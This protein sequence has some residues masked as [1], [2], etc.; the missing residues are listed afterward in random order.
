MQNRENLKTLNMNARKFIAILFWISLLQIPFAL[1]AQVTRQPFLQKLAPTSITIS[2]I[3]GTGVQG[4]VIYGTNISKLEFKKTESEEEEIYHEVD[5]KDL[6]PDTKYYYTV[7]GSTEGSEDTYFVTSPMPGTR[8]HVRVWVISDF[9]QTNS[10]QNNNREETVAN[11]KSFNKDEYH[12]N[13]ILS[14]GD[15]TEDDSRYQIQHNYFNQLEDVLRNTPLY[16]LPGNHDNHDEMINYESTFALPEKGEAGG[17]PSKTEK[18]YSFDY[19]NVHVV[20]L[21]S[22][23]EDEEGRLKQKEWLEKDLQNNKQHWL[24]ACMHRPMQS[25]GWHNTNVYSEDAQNRRDDWLS[26]LE[27]H[28]VDLILAGHNHIYERSFLV[29]NLMEP[30]TSITKNNIIDDGL[31]REDSGKPYYKSSKNNYKGM[32]FMQVFSGGVGTKHLEKWPLYPVSFSGS[33]LEG[34]VVLDIKGNRMDVKTLCNELNEQG[35][36]IWDYFTIIK[37]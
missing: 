16:T 11:W 22:E 13:F 12:T 25:G 19:A 36:H 15:Q 8:E 26:T 35:S 17:V 21:C 3:S 18:Y 6:Q 9:G 24:I 29:T 7:D 5:L 10:N 2:W 20:M 28:G 33:D 30:T 34:S 1:I 4:E 23:I 31:G 14:L 32:I 37:N 27:N